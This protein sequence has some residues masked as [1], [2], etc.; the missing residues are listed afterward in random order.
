MG[1][2]VKRESNANEVVAESGGYVL[3]RH[4]FE[5]LRGLIRARA[6]IH[7][8]DHKAGLVASRLARRLRTLQLDSFALY[9]E[10]LQ[11]FGIE[12]DA[13]LEQFIN[14]LTTN[15]TCSSR[16]TSRAAS[17]RACGSGAPRR[18]RARSPTRSR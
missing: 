4:E 5:A 7:L 10:R 11:A 13:E 14:A 1:A 17:I 3:Y 18:R 15:K 2:P 6:G 9:A 12:A 8:P 16:S